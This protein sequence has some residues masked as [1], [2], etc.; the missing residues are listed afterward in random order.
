MATAWAIPINDEQQQNNKDVMSILPDLYKCERERYAV[1]D[2]LPSSM[3]SIKSYL[4]DGIQDL[5]VVPFEPFYVHELPLNFAHTRIRRMTFFNMTIY[6][7]TDYK[8]NNVVTN[9]EV[10]TITFEAYFL[11]LSTHSCYDID[12]LQHDQYLTINGDR[13]NMHFSDVTATICIK[14]V[15]Y[16]NTNGKEMFRVSKVL[17][18]FSV[19]NA[20]FY[21]YPP[22]PNDVKTVNSM[23]DYMNNNS[24]EMAKDARLEINTIVA[25]IIEETANNIYTKFPIETLMP[26]YR[27]I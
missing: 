3:L 1:Q 11:R 10:S 16:N 17:V 12:Y 4:A 21:A 22:N 2:C 8:I 14:G 20:E 6:G 5:N 13:M 19:K 18:K 25:A 23:N 24:K 9:D 27:P 26:D 7:L 15:F